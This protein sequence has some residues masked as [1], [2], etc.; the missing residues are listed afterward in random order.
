M[1][2]LERLH[3]RTFTPLSVAVG[4]PEF[5]PIPYPELDCH[6]RGS[7]RLRMKPGEKEPSA[8]VPSGDRSIQKLTA[9]HL[10][11]PLGGAAGTLPEVVL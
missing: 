8:F 6:E 4:G 10:L 3:N 1:L 7:T 5:F 11:I 2:L 9:A